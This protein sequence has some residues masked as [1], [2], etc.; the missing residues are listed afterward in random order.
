[1]WRIGLNKS[2]VAPE[3]K[4]YRCTSF[5]AAREVLIN[6]LDEAAS[7]AREAGAKDEMAALRAAQSRIINVGLYQPN[8]VNL[9]IGGYEYWIAK[10]H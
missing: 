6:I 1:M 9:T 2:G 5:S 7:C 10:V 4:P 3:H 8:E